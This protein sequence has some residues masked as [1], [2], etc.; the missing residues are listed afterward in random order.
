[1]AIHNEFVASF[2]PPFCLKK[3]KNLLFSY[4]ALDT[5]EILELLK[6]FQGLN[7]SMNTF[8]TFHEVRFIHYSLLVHR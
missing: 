7:A 2:L 8:Y 3:A 6:I 4:E 1:M 5:D